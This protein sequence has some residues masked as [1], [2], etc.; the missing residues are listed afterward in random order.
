MMKAEIDKGSLVK[1]T[2]DNLIEKGD[3]EVVEKLKS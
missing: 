2:Y 3:H 1:K